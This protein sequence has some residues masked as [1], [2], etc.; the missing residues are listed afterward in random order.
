[1]EKQ[2]QLTRKEKNKHTQNEAWS[3]ARTILMDAADQAGIP[4]THAEKFIRRGVANNLSSRAITAFVSAAG[5]QETFQELGETL[6]AQP[7]KL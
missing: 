7:F 6:N 4:R 5:G 1:M 2:V 3:N